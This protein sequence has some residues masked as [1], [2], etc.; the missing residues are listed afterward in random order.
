MEWPLADDELAIFFASHAAGCGGTSLG[1]SLGRLDRLATRESTTREVQRG[2]TPQG[3]LPLM[4]VLVYYS[5][6]GFRLTIPCVIDGRH[7]NSW[8]Y[9]FGVVFI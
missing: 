1:T 7:L 5:R 3:S 8:T 9:G 6:I 2:T 4:G